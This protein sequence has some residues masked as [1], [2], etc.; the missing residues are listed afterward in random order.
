MAGTGFGVHLA[1]WAQAADDVAVGLT[2]KSRTKVPLSGGADFTVPDAFSEKTPDQ[3]ASGA[4]SLP[5]RFVLGSRYERGRWTAL[6]DLELTL[7]GTYR[8]LHI[9]FVEAQTPDVH[10]ATRWHKTL[11]ARVARRDARR[12]RVR[13]VAGAGR[14]ARAVVARRQSHGAHRRR[15]GGGVA[16]VH[17]GCVRRVPAP[18]VALDDGDREHGGGVLGQGA[19]RRTGFALDADEVD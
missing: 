6:A 9:D 12:V 11:A 16:L 5:D 3:E 17:G 4:L 19:L 2:Y 13:P 8:E 7:W 18:G 1:A 10:Q 14:H 15:V